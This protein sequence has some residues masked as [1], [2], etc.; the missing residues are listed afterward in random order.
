M[1]R[2]ICLFTLFTLGKLYQVCFFHIISTSPCLKTA[3][4]RFPT[5]S[6]LKEGVVTHTSKMETYIFFKQWPQRKG[7]RGHWKEKVLKCSTGVKKGASE[8]NG[9]IHR[10]AA[11]QK[12]SFTS[13]LIHLCNIYI[14]QGNYAVRH[15]GGKMD[16]N[17]FPLR[18]SHCKSSPK[19]QSPVAGEE[20]TER[21]MTPEKGSL[22]KEARPEL[23]TMSLPGEHLQWPG[24]KHQK[25]RDIWDP[26]PPPSTIKNSVYLQGVGGRE[27]LQGC[28]EHLFKNKSW[29]RG[30]AISQGWVTPTP[31]P[32]VNPLG[33]IHPLWALLLALNDCD[34]WAQGR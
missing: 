24:F 32:S 30:K 28:P 7:G 11:R 22:C 18:K 23:D 19:G 1:G 10:A 15:R 8:N 12:G 16:R 2:P 3:G 29:G 31:N 26:T 17:V 27:G 25:P 5:V 14:G 13:V 33:A 4:K 21:V 6:T 34:S 20:D 9:F